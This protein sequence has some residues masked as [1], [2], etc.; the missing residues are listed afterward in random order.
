MSESQNIPNENVISDNFNSDKVLQKSSDS[1]ENDSEFPNHL[2]DEILSKEFKISDEQFSSEII[3]SLPGIFYLIEDNCKFLQWNENFAEVSGYSDKEISQLR[4]LDFF[5]DEEK[6]VVKQK[7]EEALLKGET[8]LEAYFLSKNGKKTPFYFT[9]KRIMIDQSPYITGMGI[10]ISRIKQAEIYLQKSEENYQAFINNSSEGIWHIEISEP[11][12]TELPIEEQIDRIFEYGII[13]ECNDRM[14]RMYGLKK[15]KDLIGKPPGDFLI[16][17]DPSNQQYL[18]RI[19]ESG[20]KS[21]NSESHEKDN[22]GNDV[23]FLNNVTG[24]IENGYVTRF[25]GTQRDITSFK[26]TEQAYLELEKQLQQSQKIEPLGRLAGGIAHDFNNFL[27]VIML[28]TDI[29]KRSLPEDSPLIFR[30]DE[31]K[32]VTDNAAKMVRQL[33]AFGRK[34]TL[35]VQPTILNDVVEKFTKAIGTIVGEDI[36]IKLNLREGL[37][38]CIVDPNQI[39][40]VLMNLA[41]NSK[42][43]MPNGGILEIGTENITIDENT[44]KH[45]AQPKGSYIELSVTDTGV[46]MNSK[47]KK[48]LFEPFF[49]TKEAHKGTG[50]GLATV[51]GII[52]QSN[53]FIWVD[54]QSGKGTTFNIHFPRSDEPAKIVK[55]EI[56]PKLLRGNETIL[57]VEDEESIRRTAVEILLALGYNVLEAVDVNQALQLAESHKEPIQLLVTDVVMPKMNGKELARNIK[58]IHPEIIVLFI[59]GYTDDIIARHGILEEDVHFLGKPFSPSTLAR[60]IRQSLES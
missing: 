60:K 1:F 35:Q 26:Q 15:A 34:Q 16:R 28:H 10:D 52:K 18:R 24:I 4:P 5:P 17:S 31:I 38:V 55:Q 47:T 23:F 19:I 29:I 30:I 59:S 25:W 56:E 21:V 45:K 58:T 12:S 2:K 37:G 48:H 42:D 32:T 41:V 36:E 3:N 50:L 43:A 27:A 40:Q 13:V 39:I 51:Y 46:G 49:T 14:A 53:G 44:F 22:K 7:F 11:F 33:L 9:G 54:S 20:Y 8:S 57:L 6:E